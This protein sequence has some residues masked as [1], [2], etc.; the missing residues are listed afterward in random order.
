MHEGRLEAAWRHV[1]R[2]RVIIERQQ[3]LIARQRAFGHDAAM[4]ESLLAA[5]ERSQDIFEQDLR[6]IIKKG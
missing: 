5:F 2:G 3:A 6:D 1:E 4:S